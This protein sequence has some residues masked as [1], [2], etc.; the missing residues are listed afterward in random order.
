MTDNC[1]VFILLVCACER[2]LP[3]CFSVVDAREIVVILI[4]ARDIIVILIVTLIVVAIGLEPITLTTFVYPILHHNL[5]GFDVFGLVS[6]EVG[7][8]LAT[9]Q[10]ILEAVEGGSCSEMLMIVAFAS[11]K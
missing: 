3:S 6:P 1:D 5:E 7:V 8:C 4:I 10:V 9:D 2:T 11:K